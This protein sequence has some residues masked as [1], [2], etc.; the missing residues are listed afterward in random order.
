MKRLSILLGLMAACLLTG[1][2][3]E[4][5]SDCRRSFTLLF[6]YVGDGVTDV[7]RDKVGKVNLYVY[8]AESRA[9]VR[10]YEVDREALQELQGIR[11]DDLQ[12]GTYEAVCWGNAYGSSRV[13]NEEQR[14]GG[15]IAAPEYYDGK[16]VD[17]NN[18]LYYGNKVFT[19]TNDWT[20]QQDVCDY[21]CAHI[22]VKVRLEGFQDMVFPESRTEDGCPVDLHLD[23]LP[24]YCCF[25]GNPHDETVAYGPVLTVAE[26]DATVYE[27]AFYTL[28]FGDENDVLLSLAHPD[29]GTVFYTLSLAQFLADNQLSVEDEQEESLEILLRLSSDGVSISVQPFEEEDIHPGLDERNK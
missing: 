18:Q 10:S 17:T 9:L 20:D 25:N 12:P 28:R 16:S 29:T 15:S 27:S 14:T 4:D 3:K 21:R 1:C 23:N 22:D 7:F 2:I 24:G 8:E 19:V 6:R 11:F 26:D 5:M 13:Q